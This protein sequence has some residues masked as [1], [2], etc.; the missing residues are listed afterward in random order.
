MINQYIRP[1]FICLN[2]GLV[3]FI[4]CISHKNNM[5]KDVVVKQLT[6]STKGHMLHHNSVFSPDGQWV[7]F[8]GRNDDTKIGET[9][10]IGVVNVLTGEER[11]IYETL[12]SSIYG[13]GVGAASFHPFE[14]KVVFIHGLNNADECKPY[15]ITRRF[16]LCVDLHNPNIGIHLDAR[17]ML[18]AYTVGSLRGG[19]HSHCWSQDG[20]MLSFTYNDA[21]VDSDLRTVGVMIPIH[22]Q[23][24]VPAVA[25]NNN[26]MM[27]S[28]ILTEVVR[29]PS[30]G[31]NEI[32]KA[33]DE[34]WVGHTSTIAFQGNTRN[35][36]GETVTEIYLVDVDPTM[37]LEDPSAVGKYGQRPQVPNGIVQKRLSFTDKGISD[38]RHWLRT[39][40][41]GQYIYALARDDKGFNQIIECTVN[42]GNFEYISALPFSISSPINI[43]Y[44]GDKLTFVAQNNIYLFNINTREHFKL[45]DFDDHDSSIIGA[46]VFSRKDDK[47]AFNQFCDNEENKSVQIKLISL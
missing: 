29:N 28:A 21:L 6:N 46:P 34:C 7:V 11:D 9:T 4:G 2:L 42:T 33:F 43:S 25:G 35:L 3:V 22:E 12:N 1:W 15:D 45:T 8:D 13:P 44:D 26:G 23:I 37:I 31:S 39:S 38:F 17:D 24:D 41:D 27:Y 20:S 18:T 47:I 32:S 36:E 40:A 10:Q 19:T 5:Y 16:G 30:W 14:D